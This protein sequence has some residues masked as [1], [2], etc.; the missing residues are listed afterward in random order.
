M[1]FTIQKLKFSQK[2]VY[3]AQGLLTKIIFI[4]KKGNAK[5]GSTYEYNKKGL[6]TKT[7]YYGK[8]KNSVYTYEYSI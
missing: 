5:I 7:T 1:I 3:N 2:S 4:D 8:K 6:G